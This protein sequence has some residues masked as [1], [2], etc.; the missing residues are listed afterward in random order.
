MLVLGKQA[1]K[2]FSRRCR[3]PSINRLQLEL[4]N[5]RK[6]SPN[7]SLFK[8]TV[9]GRG[10]RFESHKYA[11]LELKIEP[12]LRR[13]GHCHAARP[14]VLPHLHIRNMLLVTNGRKFVAAGEMSIMRSDGAL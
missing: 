3:S 2:I 4:K 12:K 11:C 6:G 1:H 9:K 5:T 10:W 7:S 8:P 13:E 14:A